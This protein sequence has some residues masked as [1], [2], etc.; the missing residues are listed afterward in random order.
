MDDL[1]GDMSPM[2]DMVFLLL[3]FFMVASTMIVNRLDPDVFIPTGKSSEPPVQ[4]G[5]RILI[6]VFSDAVMAN[7]GKPRFAG[8]AGE[9]A[10]RT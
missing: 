9:P 7:K 1:Q 2:I 5:G 8:R 4:T 10:H 6:N 3:I